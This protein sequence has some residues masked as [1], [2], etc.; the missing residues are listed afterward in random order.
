MNED[1]SDQF[2]FDPET[3]LDMICSEVP[4]Y[5]ELQDAVGE[6]ATGIVADRVLE[7][8]V[9]TGETAV[10]VMA[11]HP[12][13]HL[14]GVD[15]SSEML[16]SARGRLG[17]ADLVVGRLEDPLPE[18]TFDLVVSALAVHH[19]DDR[20]KADLFRRIS[21]RLRP[22]GRFVL[23]DVVVPDDPADALTPIDD[24]GYDKPSR[25]GD[26]IRWLVEAGFQPR[27]TWAR[28]DLA[29]IAA[30]RR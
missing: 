23:A 6:A 3:Y 16:D 13:A 7:L 29:V 17:K 30:D 10:R 27:V 4:D 14:I 2:H 12:A 26:Q 28:H 19:L 20:G 5:F 11:V 22:G 24:D 9:G 25:V 15:E 18:G 21:E 1:P 8:G